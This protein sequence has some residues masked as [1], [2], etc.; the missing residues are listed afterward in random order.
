MKKQEAKSFRQELGQLEKELKH[1]DKKQKK[2][3]G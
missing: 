3:I 1:Q 2:G